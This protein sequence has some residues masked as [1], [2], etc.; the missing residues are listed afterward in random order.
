MLLWGQ[1]RGSLQEKD[2]A[3]MFTG[4]IATSQSQEFFKLLS[5]CHFYSYVMDGSTDRGTVENEPMYCHKHDT[6]EVI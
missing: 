4:Y 6:K 2:S 5:S 3:N 1:P